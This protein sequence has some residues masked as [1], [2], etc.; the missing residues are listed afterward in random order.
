MG[1]RR[2]VEKH[3]YLFA[4]DV[5]SAKLKVAGIL[6]AT[7]SP[8]RRE[9]YFPVENLRHIPTRINVNKKVQ[10]DMQPYF[11]TT[12]GKIF[13]SGS[14]SPASDAFTEDP[15]MIREIGKLA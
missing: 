8:Q 1:E 14:S 12:A 5:K 2:N 15:R 10:Q 6:A 11:S 13:G 4:E 9:G 7:P 3:P